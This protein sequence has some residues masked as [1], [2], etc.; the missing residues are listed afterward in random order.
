MKK[1]EVAG[2]GSGVRQP[3]RISY[4]RWA[5]PYVVVGGA[6]LL[7]ILTLGRAVG[8]HAH[9]IEAGI[10][11]LGPWAVVGFVVVFVLMTSVLVPD[12]L[13]A[14]IAG[15]LFGPWLGFAAVLA[16]AIAAAA[17]QYALSSRLLRERV[18]RIVRRR[19]PLA[20][21]QEAVMRDEIHLQVLLR[22]T[23]L[24][25]AS[26]SYLLG[27]AG[28]RF[29]GFLLA[30]LALTP[31]LVTEVY[32]GQAGR[33]LASMTTR[34]GAFYAHDLLLLGG[35]VVCVATLVIVSRRA[36]KALSRALA[37]AAAAEEVAVEEIL[38]TAG[39]RR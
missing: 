35:L 28:V 24:N 26:I 32:F 31:S 34:K 7:V 36:Q 21:I 23:P 18:E 10:A 33:H 39:A 4:V 1:N 20:A 27:A 3:P 37:E 11:A 38:E 16:A 25:P 12:T 19:P 8:H 9:R 5:W 13:L 29:R 30:C 2:S 15:A 6:L 14:I 22:L 17:F